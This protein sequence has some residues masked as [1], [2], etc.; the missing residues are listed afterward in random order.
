M[1][2]LGRD[3]RRDDRARCVPRL[4]GQPA[5]Q[6]LADLAVG[7]GG[8]CT[9][10]T[11]RQPVRPARGPIRHV[12]HGPVP[13]RASASSTAVG[14]RSA[15]CGAMQRSSRSASLRPVAMPGDETLDRGDT[16]ARRHDDFDAAARKHAHR[17]APRA[18]ADAHVP[19][20]RASRAD[21]SVSCSGCAPCS[22]ARCRRVQVPHAARVPC[23][24][25]VT[26]SRAARIPGSRPPTSPSMSE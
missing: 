16:D 26:G 14:C 9:R 21:H 2:S 3:A 12:L 19:A 7:A 20:R 18:P 22:A 17:Q 10:S 23:R 25:T 8:S 5:H 24:P 13:V 4:A 15:A 11:P 6:C 1:P